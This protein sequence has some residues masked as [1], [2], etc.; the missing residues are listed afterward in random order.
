MNKILKIN[1]KD[2]IYDHKNASDILNK[3]CSRA[4]LMRV[5]GGFKFGDNLIFCL[6]EAVKTEAVSDSYII[7][8]MNSL[9][10]AGLI[11]EIN[12]RY[13]SDF[14]TIFC[15]ELNNKIWGVFSKRILVEK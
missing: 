5:S 4:S 7:A 3:A 8:P 12:S 11:G 15:F 6:D 2:V 9:S 10:E 13:T 1:L 14:L